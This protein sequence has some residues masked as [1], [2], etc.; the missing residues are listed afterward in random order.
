MDSELDF[1][2]LD[3]DDETPIPP[4]PLNAEEMVALFIA[5]AKPRLVDLLK[6]KVEHFYDERPGLDGSTTKTDK[7][8][9]KLKLLR[10]S[11]PYGGM[12]RFATEEKVMGFVVNPG[13]LP[14][15][16]SMVF[17]AQGRKLLVTR[18]IESVG[19]ERGTVGYIDGYGIKVILTYDAATNE[20]TVAWQW[21]FGVL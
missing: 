14:I 10:T 16:K 19:P 15:V 4:P 6:L 12:D 17:A 13:L 1:T 3:E 5:K 21:L 2:L 8:E 20:S 9:V 18:R 11:Q 7:G